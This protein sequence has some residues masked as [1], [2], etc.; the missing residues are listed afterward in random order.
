MLVLAF[1]LLASAATVPADSKQEIVVVGR[2]IQNAKDNLQACLARHCPPPEDIDASLALAET[3]LIAGKYREARSTLLKSLGRNKEYANAYPIPVSDLYRANGNVAAHLG[4]DEDFYRSTWGI[5]R[6]LKHGLPSAKDR[7]YSAM[8]EVAEMMGR[9]RGHTRA[10]V[11]Y[12]RIAD[13]ARRDGRPD[14]AAL[15]ELRSVVRHMPPYLREEGIKRILSKLDPS[16]QAPILEGKLALAR[17]AYEDHQPA[18]GDAIVHQLS[19][20]K[21]KKPILVYAPPYELGGGPDSDDY[22][23][24]TNQ[25][26]ASSPGNVES[27]AESGN[28]GGPDFGTGHGAGGLTATHMALNVEDM[29]V[30]IGFR[31]TADGRVADLQ[32][33]RKHGD[34]GWAK[35]LL[36]SIEG[37]RY[38]PADQSS[39]TAFRRERY[40]FTSGLA[41][42]VGTHMAQHSPKPRVEYFDLSDIAAPN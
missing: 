7:Q 40:T 33:E 1:A 10:R 12:E 16:L 36:R 29:W 19:S 15:A 22:F 14:I 27:N 9:T 26:T 20:L 42:G 38:T 23:A 41:D 4:E 35:P 6:T 25:A 31:I 13:E 5:Y 37:R 28:K 32:V 18:K 3:Q 24:Q 21:I 2:Q 17:M 8:M 30:D 11:Y 34:I 39:P